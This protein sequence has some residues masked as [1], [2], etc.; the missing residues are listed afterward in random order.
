[1]VSPGSL[2]V[3]WWCSSKLLALQSGASLWPSRVHWEGYTLFKPTNSS[4]NAALC[5]LVCV[6]FV[7][8]SHLGN[9]VLSAPTVSGYF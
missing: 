9:T 8:N 6:Y 2:A 3:T 4:G 1:M 7:Y 5:S